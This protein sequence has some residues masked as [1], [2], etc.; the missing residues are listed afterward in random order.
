MSLVLFFIAFLEHPL[1]SITC[2]LNR[3]SVSRFGIFGVK[4][5]ASNCT[6][7]KRMTNIRYGYM[8]VANDDKWCQYILSFLKAASED[9]VPLVQSG[10]PETIWI[11]SF[12][13]IWVG[14]FIFQNGPDG[15]LSLSWNNLDLFWSF[16]R[17]E[18]MYDISDKSTCV[19]IMSI[20]DANMYCSSLIFAAATWEDCLGAT[21]TKWP[22]SRAIVTIFFLAALAQSVTQSLPH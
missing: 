8:Y 12:S 16:K 18:H 15:V 17:W 13:L 6:G 22:H 1:D 11:Y 10:L 9:W 21:C 4:F 20:Y 14:F 2:Q 19:N 3:P 7:V 5:Q